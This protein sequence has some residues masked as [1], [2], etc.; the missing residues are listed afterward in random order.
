MKH[1]VLTHSAFFE[2]ME[3][4]GYLHDI[5]D[6][7]PEDFTAVFEIARVLEDPNS[8]LFRSIASVMS[9]SRPTVAEPT[10][11]GREW[12]PNR[13]VSHG[14]EYEAALMRNF[15]DI[16]RIFPH[17]YLLPDEVFL[18]R[19]A[20]RSLWINL[21]RTPVVVPF[22]SSSNDYSPNNFKQKVYLLLDTSTS[23]SSHHRFQM[24]K[25][26]VYVFLKRNLKELG[27]IYLRTFDVDLGPL[28]TAT[29]ITGLKRLIRY[30][31]RLSRLG[32]G[33]AMERA[34]LQ[35]VEDIRA[36][37]SLSGAEI[38]MVTDG[39]C[40]LD[41]DR[42]RGALGDSIRINTIKIGNA[43]IYPDDKLLKEMASRG[44]S[45]RQVD[46]AKLEEQ[47]R[48]LSH[49]LDHRTA[50]RDKQSLRSRIES[51]GARAGTLRAE[52]VS[53]LKEQY[54]K[55][56]TIL[57]TVFVNI[58][59]ISLDDIF[60]L[61]QSEI[62]EIKGLLAEVESDFADEVDADSLKE[63]ALLYEHV[64]MLLKTADNAG[65][66]AQLQ[67]VADRLS[68]LLKDLAQTTGD[69]PSALK[70]IGR[71]D[72]H[73]LQMILHLRSNEG[74]S[75]AALLMAMLRRLA[76]RFL[77]LKGGRRR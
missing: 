74:A 49:D 70:G 17:Q 19:L 62:E 8:S 41:I 14:E 43:E 58:D 16:K 26:V 66:R 56:I 50:E 33:T 67:E 2:H 63:A 5:E 68:A 28:Q 55:E 61:R 40:H 46:L 71:A 22:G 73:D 31:M 77:I 7:L 39:A 53:H 47:I 9:V 42:I 37:A 76:A 20:Q 69:S 30:T 36:G 64:Q 45:P 60:T 75:I 54:G 11:Q 10:S 18:Q 24:A 57:S 52:I 12:R 48:R 32:N 51:L 6:M 4:F 15:T 38:L 23:M 25:A 29:D 3:E 1:E 59:D 72:I 34:I 65:Q 44:T 13:Q 27:H 35:A 21:P